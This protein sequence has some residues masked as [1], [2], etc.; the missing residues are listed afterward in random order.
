MRLLTLK[1]RNF[2]N[3]KSAD[4]EF[5]AGANLF[6]GENG[7]GKTNLLEALSVCLGKSF[8]GVTPAAFMPLVPLGTSE[9]VELR[10]VFL[11]GGME[12]EIVY[13]YGGGA[14]VVT[15]SGMSL[16]TAAE[17]YGKTP[18]VVLVPEHTRIIKAEPALRRDYI[19]DVAVL[20]Q[21]ARHKA[22]VKEYR[23]ALTQRGR[24][25]L[26]NC[27]NCAACRNSRGVCDI[28]QTD[29]VT[30]VQLDIWNERAARHGLNIL[31]GRLKY[32]RLLAKYAV[33]FYS[34]LSGGRERFSM[35][36]KTAL[37]DTDFTFCG[38][39][40]DFEFDKDALLTRYKT[41]LSEVNVFDK[42][43][44]GVHRD[45]IIFYIGTANG[46]A[47]P[48][49]EFASQG[50]S[51]SAAAALKIA[52]ARIIEHGE[53][54]G[55]PENPVILLDEAFTAIDL[56]RAEHLTDYFYDGSRLSEQPS[57]SRQVFLTSCSPE[58]AELV[59]GLADSQVFEVDGDGIC[60]FGQ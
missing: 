39:S 37:S 38:E 48:A 56:G 46:G 35:A 13:K 12:T 45:D 53:G 1:V 20:L 17:L 31:F 5:A 18:Y 6:Y 60:T 15:Y 27:A 2:R 26:Q 21:T 51:F 10:L 36:Y 55:A 54:V 34:E 57:D 7:T 14:P 47:R 25:I 11:R 29:C 28:T 58:T 9:D 30:A 59:R 32:L 44:Q 50:Q 52:E 33:P 23:G 42:S 16:K 19:D 24:L 43:A 4:I 49:R 40:D 22:S 41:L 3:I 8:R